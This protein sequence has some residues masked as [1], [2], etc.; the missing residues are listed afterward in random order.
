MLLDL[1][2]AG[3]TRKVIVQAPKNGFFYILDHVTGEFLS[4]E[5]FVKVSWAL[6]MSKEGRP[7]VNPK[8]YYDQDAISIYPTSGGAHNWSPMSYNP[9]TGLVYIPAF[10]T[11]FA[12]QAQAE[13][14][15]GSNGFRRPDGPTRVVEPTLGPE[16]PEGARGG[17]QAWDPVKQT[18]RWN[19]EGGGGIGGGTVTTAGNLVFQVI[20]D[21]RFRALSADKGEILYE[22]KTT[23]TG[24][25]PPIT[26][27]ADG[28]QYVAFGGGIGRAAA[29]VGP[30]DAKT[31]N[32]PVLFV[33]KVGGSAPM[34]EKV[35]TAAPAP[36]EGPA[37]EQRN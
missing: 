27:E 9:G 8:A 36:P 26:Y 5:P 2:I 6:G 30:T 29:V 7:I 33:F 17:L 28:T 24:M 12:L 20:N 25:A 22:V 35:D 32:P 1:P 4:A 23:R 14:R 13:F 16:P 19:I 15:P 37:P 18:L 21:G 3:R 11:S 31:D 34:P 10:Y